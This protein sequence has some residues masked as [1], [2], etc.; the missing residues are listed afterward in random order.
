[1]GEDNNLFVHMSTRASITGHRLRGTISP[2][3]ERSFWHK[4]LKW[5]RPE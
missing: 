3:T 1:V 4:E 2:T 5:N